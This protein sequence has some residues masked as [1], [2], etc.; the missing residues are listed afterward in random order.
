MSVYGWESSFRFL[1]KKDKKL[2]QNIA[3]GRLKQTEK[4][5]KKL[6]LDLEAWQKFM[7][8]SYFVYFSDFFFFG[9][10]MDLNNCFELQ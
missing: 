7:P 4:T 3:E 6:L 8:M 5:W 10:L 2:D 1:S 9:V